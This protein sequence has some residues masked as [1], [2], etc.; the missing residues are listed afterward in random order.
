MLFLSLWTMGLAAATIFGALEFNL[1]NEEI[2]SIHTSYHLRYNDPHNQKIHQNNVDNR[3]RDILDHCDI[4]GMQDGLALL[5]GTAGLT[6]VLG[7]LFL[8]ALL[9]ECTLGYSTIFDLDIAA[10]TNDQNTPSLPLDIDSHPGKPSGLEVECKAVGRCLNHECFSPLLPPF[11]VTTFIAWTIIELLASLLFLLSSMKPCLPLFPEQ[12]STIFVGQKI[13]WG[14]LIITLVFWCLRRAIP[15]CVDC[16]NQAKNQLSST[17]SN[18]ITSAPKFSGLSPIQLLVAL[19]IIGC[20]VGGILSI[21]N[22]TETYANLEKEA[23]CPMF[24]YTLHGCGVIVVL[25]LMIRKVLLENDPRSISIFLQTLWSTPIDDRQYSVEEGYHGSKPESYQNDD[26]SPPHRLD[27][28]TRCLWNFANQD[29]ISSYIGCHVCGSITLLVWIISLA[30]YIVECSMTRSFVWIYWMYGLIGLGLVFALWECC[31]YLGR[32]CQ[33]AVS[34][35]RSE[36]L[37]EASTK[38]K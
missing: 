15:S 32:K 27:V 30:L 16:W 22:T 2:M 1:V 12:Q 23:V 37:Q 7:S 14:T 36:I 38:V 13:L 4:R 29:H 19:K 25:A 8:C 18:S 10:R 33:E 20:S 3:T 35:A 6:V 17:A 24:G 31:L 11:F 26:V 5:W 9:Q 34:S 21:H 28:F